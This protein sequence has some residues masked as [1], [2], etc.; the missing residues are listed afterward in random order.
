MDKR[1]WLLA[2]QLFNLL[3]ENSPDFGNQLHPQ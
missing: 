2:G 3:V 1:R